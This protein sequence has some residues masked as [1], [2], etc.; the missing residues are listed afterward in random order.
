[1][2]TSCLSLLQFLA[3]RDALLKTKEGQL[4]KLQ[5]M[6]LAGHDA[7]LK[8]RREKNEL[9][10][11]ALRCEAQE[12]AE[13]VQERDQAAGAAAVAEATKSVRSKLQAAEDEIGKLE[14]QLN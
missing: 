3:D 9:R 7:L 11:A 5:E 14:E 10:H 1:M 13:R 6:F 4:Q 8:A 2:K 12:H